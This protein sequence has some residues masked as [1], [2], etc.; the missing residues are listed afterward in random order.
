MTAKMNS[1]QAANLLKI[2]GATSE[3]ARSLPVVAIEEA[4]KAVMNGA[5]PAGVVAAL[6][7]AAK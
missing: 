1:L 4:I 3:L 5:N 2:N 6:K 7:D